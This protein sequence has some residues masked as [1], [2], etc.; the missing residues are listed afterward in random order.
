MYVQVNFPFTFDDD[1]SISQ[2]HI[3]SLSTCSNPEQVISPI[4]NQLLS[5]VANV[6]LVEACFF[7]EYILFFTVR[8]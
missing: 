4:C 2:I 5:F 8:S 6:I 3:I 7:I 1:D